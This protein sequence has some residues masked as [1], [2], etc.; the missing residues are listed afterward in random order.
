MLLPSPGFSPHGPAGKN[1]KI[2]KNFKNTLTEIRLI[3]W[4]PFTVQSVFVKYTFFETN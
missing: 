4:I 2:R 3:Q 1:G